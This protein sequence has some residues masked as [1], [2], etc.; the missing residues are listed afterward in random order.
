MKP[1]DDTTTWWIPLG[2][3]PES[4]GKPSGQAE[5]LSDKEQTIS[6]LNTDFYKLNLGQTGF[7]RVNYTP[8]RLEKLGASIQRLSVADRVGLVGDA[9]SIAAAGGGST[10]GFLSLV[11]G[12]KDEENYL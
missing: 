12:M 11:A 2:I 7:Y 10:V 5:A 4:I 6:G 8:E 3:T 1:E 9:A